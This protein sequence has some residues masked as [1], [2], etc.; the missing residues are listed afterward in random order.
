MFYVAPAN[1]APQTVE[2]YVARWEGGAEGPREE[3]F[4][5]ATHPGPF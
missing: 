3:Q 1:I 2:F 5:V 4:G